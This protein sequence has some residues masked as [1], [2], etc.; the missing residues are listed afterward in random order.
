MPFIR[1][2]VHVRKPPV[3][4]E[5]D[6]PD[7]LVIEGVRWDGDVFRTFAAPSD[8]CLY[9]LRRDGDAVSLV[10]VRNVEEAQRFFAE[11]GMQNA[12]G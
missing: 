6:V 5:R 9:A 12:E 7:V 10:T 4:V 8:D 2:E 1:E 11:C 3:R